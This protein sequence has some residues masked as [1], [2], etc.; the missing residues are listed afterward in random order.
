MKVKRTLKYKVGRLKVKIK[1]QRERKEK[2]ELAQLEV[3]EYKAL[4]KTKEHLALATARNKATNAQKKKVE[5]L[6]KEKASR[7]K[8]EH[9]IMSDINKLA[10]KLIAEDKPKKRTTK[11]SAKKTTTRKSSK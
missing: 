4:K 2:R 6:T 7:G 11:K 10:K 8:Q 9:S 5:A 3:Q 1:K